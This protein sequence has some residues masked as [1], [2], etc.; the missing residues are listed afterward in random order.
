MQRCGSSA[1]SDAGIAKT[2]SLLTFASNVIRS[3]SSHKC[4]SRPARGALVSLD[5]AD[6]EAG[7]STFEPAISSNPEAPAVCARWERAALLR[8]KIEALRALFVE[9]GD[10]TTVAALDLLL[11]GVEEARDRAAHSASRSE[12]SIAHTCAFI[13][14]SKR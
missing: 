2:A 3:V 8:E 7:N 10:T 5:T 1:A 6:D 14:G 11:E 4:E 9:E 12:T 13:A